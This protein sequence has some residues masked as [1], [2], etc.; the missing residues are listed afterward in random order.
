MVVEPGP[1]HASTLAPFEAATLGPPG[2]QLW[3]EVL[4]NR[5]AMDPAKARR[6]SAALV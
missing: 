5:L 3:I 6:G 1:P 2:L 4:T